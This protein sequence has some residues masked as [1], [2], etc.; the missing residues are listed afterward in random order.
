MT[1]HSC[2]MLTLSTAH[3]TEQTCNTVLPSLVGKIPA[4]PK[5]E[6]GWFIYAAIEQLGLEPTLPEDLTHVL[7][8]AQEQNFDYVMFDQDWPTINDIPSFDW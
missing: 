2:T 6:C 4:W 8:Y 5:A 1:E 7:N 3:L